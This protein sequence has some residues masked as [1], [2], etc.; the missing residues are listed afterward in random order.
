MI[1][2]L[3]LLIMSVFSPMFG[4]I[5]GVVKIEIGGVKLI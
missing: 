4:F 2:F 5:F 1:S 3:N